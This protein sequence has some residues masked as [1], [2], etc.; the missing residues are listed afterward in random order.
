MMIMI[1]MMRED[2]NDE[3]ITTISL[4]KNYVYLH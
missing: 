1:L 3:K 2:H 4:K